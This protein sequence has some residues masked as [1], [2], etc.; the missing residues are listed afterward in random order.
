MGHKICYPRK[1]LHLEDKRKQRRNLTITSDAFTGME[2]KGDHGKVI[3]ILRFIKHI[4][5]D[6]SRS[7]IST[8]RH[9]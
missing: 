3:L 4:E 1:G 5:T 7:F 9:P 2:S 8:P 6:L